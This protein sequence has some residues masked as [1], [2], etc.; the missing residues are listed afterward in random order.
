MTAFFKIGYDLYVGDKYEHQKKKI[1]K[2]V[3]SVAQRT[4]ADLNGLPIAVDESQ[5]WRKLGRT[6][7]PKTLRQIPKKVGVTALTAASIPAMRNGC[8]MLSLLMT[9][10]LLKIRERLRLSVM[11]SNCIR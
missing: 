8:V 6:F 4:G 3:D 10:L 5:F 11:V 1:Q 2:Y 9:Q 7:W